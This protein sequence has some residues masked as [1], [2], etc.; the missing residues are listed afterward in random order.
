MEPASKSTF[1]SLRYSQIEKL[2]ISVQM[3]SNLPEDRYEREVSGV[4]VLSDQYQYTGSAE[5]ALRHKI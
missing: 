1:G 3:R 4:C 2:V 5:T